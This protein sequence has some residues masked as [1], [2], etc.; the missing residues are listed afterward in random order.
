MNR[1]GAILIPLLAGF[2]LTVMAVFWRSGWW[3]QRD[4]ALPAEPAAATVEARPPHLRVVPVHV[5]TASAVAS[6]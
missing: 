5:L 6:A 2:L 4:A 3:A 1:A